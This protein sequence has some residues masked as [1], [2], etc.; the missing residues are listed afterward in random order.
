[1]IEKCIGKLATFAAVTMED[2][3]NVSLQVIEMFYTFGE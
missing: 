1:M 3:P 2:E